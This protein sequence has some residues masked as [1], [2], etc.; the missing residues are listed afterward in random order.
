L[1]NYFC[2]FYLGGSL[3]PSFPDANTAGGVPQYPGS[4]L[5]PGVA[6]NQGLPAVP[7]PNTV[8]GQSPNP[9]AQN[10]FILG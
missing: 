4:N 6:P 10:P 3:L 7:Y 9:A 8:V 2:C 1:Q 5:A